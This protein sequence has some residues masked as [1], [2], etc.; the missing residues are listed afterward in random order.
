MEKLEL[1]KIKKKKV[2]TSDDE[3]ETEN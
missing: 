2:D 3:D 1:T